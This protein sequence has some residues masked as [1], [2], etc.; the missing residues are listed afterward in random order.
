ME[1]VMKMLEGFSGLQTLR[2]VRTALLDVIGTR[3]Q[4]MAKART[5]VKLSACTFLF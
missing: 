4:T 3:E 2:A 5:F 1:W